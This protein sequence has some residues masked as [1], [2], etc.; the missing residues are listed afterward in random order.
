[1]TETDWNS[2]MM[3]AE[4]LQANAT[5]DTG[6]PSVTRNIRQLLD[7]AENLWTKVGVPGVEAQGNIFLC[8]RG[9]DA[10]QVSKQLE[11]L[12][13]VATLN[14]LDPKPDM[15]VDSFV[16][17]EVQNAILGLIE[18]VKKSNGDVIERRQT[19][20]MTKNW[21]NKKI[22][23]VNSFPGYMPNSS[24]PTSK[25]MPA[26]SKFNT[27]NFGLNAHMDQTELTYAQ[28]LCEYNQLVENHGVQKD[29]L[30][31]FSKAAENAHDD[32]VNE[33]WKIVKC[34][35]Q[36]IPE[37]GSTNS[38]YSTNNQKLLISNARSYLEQRYIIFMKSYVKSHLSKA[39]VGGIPGT[40][41]LVRS[42]VSVYINQY[43][44]P[45][46][47]FYDGLPFW[48]FLYYLIRCGDLESVVK[49]LENDGTHSELLN[50]FKSIKSNHQ[51][52]TLND[53]NIMSTV[54]WESSDPFKKVIYSLVLAVDVTSKHSDVIKTADDYLW[55]KLCQVR[56]EV[57][58]LTYP[59]LQTTIY[60]E[61]GEQFS[62][63]QP[64]SYFQLLFL[65]GQF[66]SAIEFIFR[67]TKLRCHAIHIAIAL[68]EINILYLPKDFDQPILSKDNKQM[69]VL[70]LSRM[71]KI[72]CTKF[73]NH[74]LK[75]AINY[76]YCLR[77]AESNDRTLFVSQVAAL[78]VETEEYEKVF[79]YLKP[80]G[81]KMNGILDSFVVADHVK[82]E[83]IKCA[84]YLTEQKCDFEIAA[85]L[86]E[87]V[88]QY[89]KTL[90][91][92]NIMLSR[93]IQPDTFSALDKS[94]RM[95][96]RIYDYA[97]VLSERLSGS[98]I[99]ASDEDIFTFNMLKSLFVFFQLYEDK[100]NTLAFDVLQT[101]G[102]IP[103]SSDQVEECLSA[104]KK[105]GELIL[106][107]VPGV[108]TATMNMLYSQYTEIK[109]EEESSRSSKD[110]EQRQAQLEYIRNRAKA[111]T[112][113]TGRVP[114][115]I[116]SEIINHL[117][118]TEILLY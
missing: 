86:Y 16:K 11:K 25:T 32:R 118:Q 14:T 70:N 117:V 116:N 7:A 91:L 17:N 107:I 81:K 22:N 56:N 42:F 110:P 77:H 30:Q 45:D 31:S 67:H 27:T 34:M 46:Q 36:I 90:E 76:Y 37:Y 75:M 64:M 106:R 62:E 68:N 71:I 1:M 89:D 73:E 4:K 109:K 18:S 115:Q 13:S 26:L 40:F 21:R 103:L 100:K 65:T 28:H 99:N 92:I 72:Y 29:I 112:S 88:G 104:F 66:E 58:K 114:F 96:N 47:L 5:T 85:R 83:I 87:L 84:A 19:D 82:L 105:F 69:A 113:F 49:V 41:P 44:N 35:S 39:K 59:I 20:T 24:S 63:A 78:V 12:S 101:I 38:R 111:I 53:Q 102:L 10:P 97:E 54:V 2:I 95:K 52:T 60:K 55:L 23:I 74:D 15:D 108:M 94:P 9:V 43:N 98:E 3:T 61:Y 79:G 51:Y 48:P 6:M 80:D 8:S 93:I 33:M 50:V 57:G